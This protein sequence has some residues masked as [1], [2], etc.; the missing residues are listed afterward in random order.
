MMMKM[1]FPADAGSDAGSLATRAARS[2]DG[3]YYFLNG[4]KAFISGGGRS[5]VYVVMTRTG[6]V[7]DILTQLPG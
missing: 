4:S 1:L 2:A 6:S 7:Y 3:S 5:E